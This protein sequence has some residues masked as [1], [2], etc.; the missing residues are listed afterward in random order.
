MPAT[1]QRHRLLLHLLVSIWLIAILDIQVTLGFS[2]L[3]HG[4]N[5]GLR[6]GQHQSKPKSNQEK[7]SL[8]R[9]YFGHLNSDL[10]IKEMTKDIV[11]LESVRQSLMR[12]EETLIFALI[13]R[14]AFRYNKYSYREKNSMLVPDPQV[15]LPLPC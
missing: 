5:V 9:A 10:S 8:H 13:E 3:S 14:A 1:L 15:C 11:S 2:L 6:E 7:T 4:V 12:Q